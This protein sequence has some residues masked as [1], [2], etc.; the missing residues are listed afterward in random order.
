MCGLYCACCHCE[1]IATDFM[2][3]LFIYIVILIRSDLGFSGDAKLGEYIVLIKVTTGWYIATS[4]LLARTVCFMQTTL[5]LWEHPS[6]GK[7]CKM[8]SEIE[9]GND[10]N[11]PY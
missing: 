3:I 10:I 1:E 2:Q 4:I 5:Y 8:L 11:E 6:T 9:F 7:L